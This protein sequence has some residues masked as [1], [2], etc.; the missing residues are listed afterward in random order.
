MYNDGFDFE[1]ISCGFFNSRA[2]MK[3]LSETKKRITDCYELEYIVEDG[4]VSYINNASH[5]LKKGGIIFA[6]S[7]DIRHSKLH[8]K[9]YFFHFNIKN[10][11]LEKMLR[12]SMKS[13][14]ADSEQNGDITKDIRDIF[15]DLALEN[16]NDIIKM[17]IDHKFLGLILKIAHME[18]TASS[19]SG[20]QSL[21]YPPTIIRSMDFINKNYG[22]DITLSDIAE[23]V[24]LTPNYFHKLFLKNVGIRVH[25]YLTSTRIKN[26]ALLLTSTDMPIADI[27]LKVGF[28]SQSHFTAAFK[29]YKN[30][31]PLNYR[32][33]G[34]LKYQSI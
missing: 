20:A 34:Y 16:K 22:N 23:S 3:K 32:E 30:V 5:D 6:K 18:D 8:F 1:I 9:A 13:F 31:T 10:K 15:S 21:I 33:M 17:K 12:G 28:S 14:Y 2:V 4:G 19:L 26:A 25:E 7:G 29:K 27:S 24:Y 11:E